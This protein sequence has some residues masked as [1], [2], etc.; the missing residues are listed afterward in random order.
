VADERE[1]RSSQ[2]LHAAVR[3]VA[4]IIPECVNARGPDPRMVSA[5]MAVA[6]E[7]RTPSPAAV[8]ARFRKSWP[9]AA[10]DD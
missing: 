9:E 1:R 8:R 4:H 7:G 10:K 2:R 3:W 5:Y 6:Y